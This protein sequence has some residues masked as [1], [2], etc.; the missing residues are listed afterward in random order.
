M[1]PQQAQGMVTAAGHVLL[2]MLLW[3]QRSSAC[4]TELQNRHFG[5][6]QKSRKLN[7]C[8]KSYFD[9]FPAVCLM[10]RLLWSRAEIK[11]KPVKLRRNCMYCLLWASRKPTVVHGHFPSSLVGLGSFG[12]ARTVPPHCA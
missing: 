3:T 10:Y 11:N 12:R 7:S 1:V 9:R 8:C 6:A 2:A 5:G 4:C